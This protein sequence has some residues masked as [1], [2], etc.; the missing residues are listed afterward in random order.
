MGGLELLLADCA[1]AHP[2][3]LEV[4][5]EDAMVQQRLHELAVRELERVRT[6]ARKGV[7]TGAARV[8]D[9][10]QQVQ[11]LAKKSQTQKEQLAHAAVMLRQISLDRVAT[12]GLS[13]ADTIIRDWEVGILTILNAEKDARIRMILMG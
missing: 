4:L 10:E 8:R 7:A 5:R 2:T 6:V 9:L 11:C 3:E 1:A 12:A 13:D